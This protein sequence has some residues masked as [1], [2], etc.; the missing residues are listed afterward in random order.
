MGMSMRGRK[1]WSLVLVFC[2]VLVSVQVVLYLLA[3]IKLFMLFGGVLVVFLALPLSYTV[4]YL[5]TRYQQSKSVRLM[6]KLAYILA[7]AFL[8]PAITLFWLA[9]ISSATGVATINHLGPLGTILLMYVVA[10]I[11]GASITYSIGKRRNFM[12]HV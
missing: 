11:V 5:Q 4:M 9:L 6:N 10:P 1:F 8:A 2:A 12:P 7:G 3:Y